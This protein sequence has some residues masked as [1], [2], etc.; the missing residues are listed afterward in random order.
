MRDGKC[1]LKGKG[2]KERKRERRKKTERES[3]LIRIGYSRFR[4]VY[5]R[6]ILVIRER[7][8]IC[9]YTY[10]R[11]H[12]RTLTHIHTQ[13]RNIRK[14]TRIPKYKSIYLRPIRK[15]RLKKG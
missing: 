11:I 4:K 14:R 6:F 1:Y 2:R 15:N 10:I 9:R 7:L 5:D 8:R 3:I 13:T 12:K